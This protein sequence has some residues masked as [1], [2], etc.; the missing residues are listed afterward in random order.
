[1]KKLV[2][3]LSIFLVFLSLTYI[4]L[5][6]KESEKNLKMYF[7]IGYNQG[8]F[9]NGHVQVRELEYEGTY[10]K[11]KEN[12]GMS[13]WISPTMTLG[14]NFSRKNIF[15]FTYTR[16]FFKGRE[17]IPERTWYNGTLYA[18]SSKATIKN[19]IYRRFELAWKARIFH[20]HKTEIYTRTAIDYELL[21]FYV[22]APIDKE[23]PKAETYEGFWRQQLPLPTIGVYVTHHLSSQWSIN[24]EAFATYLPI[25]ETWMKERG[26]M[27]V[28]QSNIDVNLHLSYQGKYLSISPGIWF[29]HYEIKEESRED[30]N[31]FLING[32]GYS[33]AAAL[34]F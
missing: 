12:L 31:A 19:T 16:H 8:I 5:A 28:G 15:E 23:S 10:L 20:S 34:R 14:M 30:E 33:L 9:Y 2:K 11:L 7:Q 1:M 26:N 21:K 6:Q 18:P 29:K 25:V 27:H 32:F 13:S 3:T 17:F 22:D 24:G 4:C